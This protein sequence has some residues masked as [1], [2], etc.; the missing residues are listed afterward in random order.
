MTSNSNEVR[1]RFAPSPTGHLHVGGARTALFNYLYTKSH[2]GKFLLRIEDTDKER[3]DDSMVV[4][5]KESLEW[6]G[7]KWDE[8]IV[9]QSARTAMYNESISKLL[10]THMAY[11]CFCEPDDLDKKRKEAQQNKRQYKY[12]GTCRNLLN[13]EIESNIEERK[14]FAI[15]FATPQEGETMVNDLIYGDV[16]FKNSEIDDFIIARRDGSPTYQLAVVTDDWKMNISH[17]IRGEDHLSNTPKQLLLFDGLG[18]K[19]PIYAHLPL[20]LGNDNQRLSK[21]HGATA[22][23]EFRNQGILPEALLNHLSLLGW[24]P[25]D[26]TEFMDLDEILKRFRLDNVSR[27]SAVFDHKKLLWINGQHLSSKSSE[28]LLP[29]VENEWNLPAADYEGSDYLMK[30]INIVKTRAKT[31]EEL[32]NFGNY[33]FNDP[34]EFDEN[35]VKKYWS[36]NAVNENIGILLENLSNLDDFSE[37]KLEEVLRST[38]DSI[39]IKAASLIHPTRLALTGFGVSPGIFLVMNMLGKKV[40][41]RRL[42]SAFEKFP[43]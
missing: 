6:L 22:V 21:R 12:D 33:F 1:V 10:S 39:G 28:E 36:E 38:A 43:V 24:S 4:E 19:E 23:T 37:E 18:V 7:L 25:K 15:R 17:V 5:I 3:S 30:V 11:R 31:R 8:E 14:L 41:L 42:N 26:D 40:V 16:V 32:V 35:A 2:N 20:I 29:L 27:K 9:Y 13:D 34:T